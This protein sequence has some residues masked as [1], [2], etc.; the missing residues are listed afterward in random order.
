MDSERYRII[1]RKRGQALY[2][3]LIVFLYIAGFTM[4]I[5]LDQINITY[6]LIGLLVLGF[7]FSFL[8]YFLWRRNWLKLGEMAGLDNEE[9]SNGNLF[10]APMLAGSYRGYR[11]SLS[12]FTTGYGRYKKHYTKID[13]TL[14]DELIGNFS[15]VKKSLLQ[16]DLGLTGIEE[17]D[18]RFTLKTDLEWV[19]KRLFH[20]R[21][22]E[23]GL[24]DLHKQC[25]S[26]NLSASGTQLTF[27]ER[28]RIKDTEYLIALMDYMIKMAMAI[29]QNS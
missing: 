19:E 10:K 18:K 17:F 13:M 2:T 4:I 9:S 12:S 14:P 27:Q 5:L 21:D 3:I 28:G 29:R 25:R 26:M 22:I 20:N 24:Y 16:T 7:G 15:L 1:P 11:I 8:E 23:E 6:L